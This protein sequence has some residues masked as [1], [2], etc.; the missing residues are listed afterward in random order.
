MT[1][2]GLQLFENIFFAQTE[3]KNRFRR[4]VLASPDSTCKSETG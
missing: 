4:I 2:V 3:A 1:G